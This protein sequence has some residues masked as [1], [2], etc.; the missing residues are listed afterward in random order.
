LS[1]AKEDVDIKRLFA[2]TTVGLKP[3]IGEKL[4]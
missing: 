1:K 3:L 2:K 4:Y